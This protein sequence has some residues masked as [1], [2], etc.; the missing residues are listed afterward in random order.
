MTSHL[1][2]QHVA[3]VVLFAALVGVIIGLEHWWAQRGVRG[4]Q[5]RWLNELQMIKKNW[6]IVAPT[7][8]SVRRDVEDL[9][10]RMSKLE[11]E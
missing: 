11:K 5:Q 8:E 7:L 1:F 6:G 10:T 3:L 4:W 9:K 2:W